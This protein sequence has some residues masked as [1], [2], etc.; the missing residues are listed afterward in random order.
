MIQL[1]KVCGGL[2]SLPVFLNKEMEYSAGILEQSMGAR[3]KVGIRV[4]VPRRFL[5]T[6]TEP[7]NRFQGSIP[8][9]YVARRSGAGMLEQTMGARN[10]EEIG[11]KGL[12][13]RIL[14]INPGLLKVLKTV[15]V[16]K[17]FFYSVFSPHRLF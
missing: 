5:K 12:R 16:K 9:D 13:N 4:V 10:Q 15:S 6:F 14:G 7:R 3:N 17:P 2:R 11:Y 8:R 1:Y